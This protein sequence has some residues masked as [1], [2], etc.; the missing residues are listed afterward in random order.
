MQQI[1]KFKDISEVIK[2]ANNTKYG[3]AAGVISNDINK[4]MAITNAMRAG[5]VW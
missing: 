3:L 1:Y 4:V 2:R 5:T